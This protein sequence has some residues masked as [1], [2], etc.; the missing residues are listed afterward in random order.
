MLIAINYHYIRNSFESPYPS[1]FGKTPYEFEMQMLE[2]KKHGEFISQ[3]DLHDAIREGR[4]LPE[5]SFIITF[6][7]GLNE[8]YEFALPILKKHNIPAIFFVNTK[9]IEQPVVLNVHKIHLLR[10][11][12]SPSELLEKLK[13]SK[14]KKEYLA[15]SDEIQAKAISHYNYDS[16]E[17]AE[18]KYLINFILPPKEIN[19]YI[20]KIFSEF[21]GKQEAAINRKLY[22]SK[23]QIREL[24]DMG[25][26][27]SHSHDHYPIGLLS[28][29]EKEFEIKKS[30]ETLEEI[31]GRPVVSF[32]YPYGSK[33]SVQDVEGVLKKH[34]Y[35]FAF[36]MERAVNNSLVHPFHLSRFDNNDMPKGKAFKL[37]G[38]HDIFKDYSMRSCE[39]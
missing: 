36:T 33:E 3:Y 35:T 2:L 8:Q 9:P 23:N 16:H 1:I 34:D 29:H 20:N 15:K 22:M 7:D 17:T 32:S 30:K 24:S 39:L 14:I 5:R 26:I 27:G 13:I 11:Q 18:L 25:F 31:T 12:I 38:D 21:Y 28:D 10:S 37:K 4:K 6:D 19:K